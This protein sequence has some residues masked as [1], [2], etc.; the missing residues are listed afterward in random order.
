MTEQP[1]IIPGPPDLE[2]RLGRG[3][4][5]RS[6]L[7][8][9]PHSQFGGSMDNNVVWALAEAAQKQ[10]CGWLRFNFRGV[11]RS[12]GR[13][14]H[15]RGEADDVRHA[16]AF[17]AGQGGADVVLAGYSFGAWVAAGVNDPHPR[18]TAT[19]LI[20]PPEGFLSMDRPRNFEPPI[21]VIAGDNDQ[22]CPRPL[23]ENLLVRLQEP[24]RLEVLSGVDHFF[25]GAEGKVIDLVTEFLSEPAA[26]GI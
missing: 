21:L 5:P 9:H 23:L 17:L 14:D 8:T 12:E 7:I 6:L 20:A 22:F 19:I 10:G 24:R 26:G 25:A 4:S 13:F 15:G 11:G 16:L 1:V 2:G 3:S 18:P